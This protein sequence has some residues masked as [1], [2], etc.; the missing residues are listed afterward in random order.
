MLAMVFSLPVM[1]G[2]VVWRSYRNADRRAQ[3]GDALSTPG[4]ERWE[5]GREE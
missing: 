2:F 4:A 5:P 3:R 1:F